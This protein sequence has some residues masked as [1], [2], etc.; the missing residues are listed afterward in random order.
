MIRSNKNPSIGSYSEM[1]L[2]NCYSLLFKSH[3]GL[4]VRRLNTVRRGLVQVTTVAWFIC[5]E[6][7]TICVEINCVHALGVISQ[8]DE[9]V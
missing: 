9:R 6:C 4:L 2:W 7:C 5:C 3:C 1:Y 8:T